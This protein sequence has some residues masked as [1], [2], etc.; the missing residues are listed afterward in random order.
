M[1]GVHDVGSPGD[2]TDRQTT[3]KSL[4]RGDEIRNEPEVLT[5]EHLA[6]PGNAGL[7]FVRDKD[8]PV[9]LAVLGEPRQESASRDN[10][11]TF[12]LHGFDEQTRDPVSADLLVH[13]GDS[14]IRTRVLRT[15]QAVVR[16]CSGRGS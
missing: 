6:G 12:T 9:L 8:D 16:S 10:H 2:R 1:N 3:A 15:A 4:G 14:Q 11:T 13:R 7:H 5:R